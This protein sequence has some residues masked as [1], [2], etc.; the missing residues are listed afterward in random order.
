LG[1]NPVQHLIG[2]QVLSH[3]TAAQKAKVTGRSFFPGLI[4]A[5]FRAGLHAAFDFAIVASLLAAAASWTRGGHVRMPVP[6]TGDPSTIAAASDNGNRA[7][8]RS[9]R[10][11]ANVGLP[12]SQPAIES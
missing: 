8:G 1:V 11:P 10:D 3:L 6:T 7:D 2:P 5:P 12:R 4:T 9:S